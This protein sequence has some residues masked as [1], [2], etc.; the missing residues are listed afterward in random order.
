MKPGRRPQIVQVPAVGQ[1]VVAV[2][3]TACSRWLVRGLLRT[4]R[5][6]DVQRSGI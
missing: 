2:G 3:Q 5:R 1:Q 4:V 6:A